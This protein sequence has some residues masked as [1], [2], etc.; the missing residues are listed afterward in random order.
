[1]KSPSFPWKE[2]MFVAP[3]YGSNNTELKRCGKCNA[4]HFQVREAARGAVQYYLGVHPIELLDVKHIWLVVLTI[5]KNI[6]QWEGLS[7][8]L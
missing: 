5:L 6:S 1:M 3:T 8:I 4:R 7:H 2:L